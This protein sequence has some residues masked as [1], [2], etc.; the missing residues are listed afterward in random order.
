[1][2]FHVQRERV[3]GGLKIESLGC[4]MGLHV[5]MVGIPRYGQKSE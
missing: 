1:M 2:G 5:Q 3:L 4:H